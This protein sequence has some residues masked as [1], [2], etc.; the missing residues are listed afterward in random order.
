MAGKVERKHYSVIF[1]RIDR[2]AVNG[3]NSSNND[4]NTVTVKAII[5]NGVLISPR[6]NHNYDSGTATL[7]TD[8]N[9]TAFTQPELNYIIISDNT[10]NILTT[11]SHEIHHTV[12]A[13]ALHDL[14]DPENDLMFYAQNPGKHLLQYHGL[15]VVPWEQPPAIDSQ[16]TMIHKP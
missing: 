3:Y 5:G 8:S 10:K 15:P 13:G 1:S 16:W 11:V 6:P 4:I 2:R 14:S 12:L 9:M 7:W